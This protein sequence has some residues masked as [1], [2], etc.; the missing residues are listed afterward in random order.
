M[1]PTISAACYLE[2]I[3]PEPDSRS[4]IELIWIQATVSRIRIACEKMTPPALGMLRDSVAGAASLPTRPGWERKA[5][6]H[7][8][9]FRLLA[10][11]AG[12]RAGGNPGGGAGIASELM[13]AVGPA[14]NGM[15][16]SS[17]QRL[18][19]HLLTGDAAA[20]ER[21]METH[22]RA[23]HYMWRLTFASSAA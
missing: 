20:A 3:G 17:R 5:A 12:D 23:L 9:V 10:Q 4:A 11:I 15:I 14:A 7:A 18:L 13:R 6:A 21:E 22:L 2:R 19:G 1:T 16:T 8:E